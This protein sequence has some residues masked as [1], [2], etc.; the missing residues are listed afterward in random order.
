M[1]KVEFEAWKR[2]TARSRHQWIIDEIHN[3]R[4]GQDLVVFKGGENGKFFRIDQSGLCEVGSYEGAIPHIGEA[5]FTITGV[6]KCETF[7]DGVTRLLTALGAS[8]LLEFVG[9]K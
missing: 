3:G 8:F 5:I 6:H 1:S 2:E 7:D 9:I 4:D